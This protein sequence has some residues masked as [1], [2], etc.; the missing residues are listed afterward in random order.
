MVW[1]TFLAVYWAHFPQTSAAL[2]KCQI[3]PKTCWILAFRWIYHFLPIKEK[4]S[5]CQGNQTD[6]RTCINCEYS[7]TY[8]LILY[9]YTFEERKSGFGLWKPSFVLLLWFVLLRILRAHN[10]YSGAC[11]TP[12]CWLAGRSFGGPVGW[13]ERAIVVG[14]W[15]GARCGRMVWCGRM[16]RCGRM[17]WWWWWNGVVVVVVCIILS[18]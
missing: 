13:Q 7:C 6:S 17:V 12:A 16:V 8:D 11:A 15:D 2:Y 9:F 4:L 14:R 3:L 18:I 5:I 10:K 1:L